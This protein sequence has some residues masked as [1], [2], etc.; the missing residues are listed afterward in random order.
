MTAALSPQSVADLRACAEKYG[1]AAVLA[2]ARLRRQQFLDPRLSLPDKNSLDASAVVAAIESRVGAE[3]GQL[4]PPELT[5]PPA[6]LDTLLSEERVWW[7]NK[8]VKQ[9]PLTEK[10]VVRL[11]YWEQLSLEKIGEVVGFTKQRA[12]Q[13][14]Q[15]ALVRLRRW[16]YLN[17]L[18]KEAA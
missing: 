10:R 7:V 13:V 15:Q 3:I 9:L 6:Q 17:W 5:I 18:V 8:A 4:L 1:V 2:E 12:D 11:R 14:H 16:F